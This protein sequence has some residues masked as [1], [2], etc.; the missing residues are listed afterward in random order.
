MKAE[1]R[2]LHSPDALDLE[3]FS[4][5]APECFGILVQAM[6]GPQGHSGAEAFDFVLCTP[7]WLGEQL[8]REDCLWLQEHL[9]VA[10][11]DYGALVVA[12]EGICAR[13]TGETWTEVALK[14]NRFARWEFADYRDSESA[15]T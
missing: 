9:L 7:A 5:A 15:D 13:V 2:R 4:P 6:V 11:Y 10:K 12:V 1:L 8:V 14:L 3:R